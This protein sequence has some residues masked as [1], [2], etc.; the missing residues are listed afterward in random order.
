[1]LALHE[2]YIKHIKYESMS[3]KL[4]KTEFLAATVPDYL[5]IGVFDGFLRARKKK[6]HKPR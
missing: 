1:M 5:R 4:G 2:E 6:D 3:P